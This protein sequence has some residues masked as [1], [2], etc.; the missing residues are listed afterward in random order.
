[1]REWQEEGTWANAMGKEGSGGGRQTGKK[2]IISGNGHGAR[3]T[4][5]EGMTDR[6]RLK[7]EPSFN[8]FRW[9]LGSIIQLSKSVTT[10]DN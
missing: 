2:K 5:P 3:L 7:E 1:M 8:S 9:F 10:N 6:E 4:R